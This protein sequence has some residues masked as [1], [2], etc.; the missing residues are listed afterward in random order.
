VGKL[1]KTDNIFVVYPSFCGGNHLVNLIALCHNVEPSWKKGND[2]LRH[3]KDR[4]KNDGGIDAGGFI[5]HYNMLDKTPANERRLI[6]HRESFVKQTANGY[7][8]LLQGHHHSYKKL[9]HG[10]CNDEYPNVFDGI[11]N[12]KWIMIEY[13]TNSTSLCS[14]RLQIEKKHVELF[15]DELKV[16]PKLDDGYTWDFNNFA[17]GNAEKKQEISSIYNMCPGTNAISI[18][19]EIYFTVEG[20]EYLRGILKGYFDLELPSIADE[21]HAEWTRMIRRRVAYYNKYEK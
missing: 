19:P 3:Y 12:V 9:A 11:D 4:N 10:Y 18:D 5:A 14:Q 8:N 17:K 13:P 16:Y 21:V 20:S 2:L 1:G 7:V 6:E 15:E